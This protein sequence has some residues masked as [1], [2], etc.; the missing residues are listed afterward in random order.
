MQDDFALLFAFNRWANSKRVHQR[1]QRDPFARR[2]PCDRRENA[3]ATAELAA[4]RAA[5]Q[6]RQERGVTTPGK[7]GCTPRKGGHIA[8][9]FECR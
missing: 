2:A 3:R 7:P 6:P 8:S 9:V 1:G 5:R 4:W